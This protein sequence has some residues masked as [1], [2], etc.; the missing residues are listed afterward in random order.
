MVCRLGSDYWMFDYKFFYLVLFLV[1]IRVFGCKV[2]R[3]YFFNFLESRKG[4]CGGE[5]GM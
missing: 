5:L 4:F 1:G 3:F 2:L